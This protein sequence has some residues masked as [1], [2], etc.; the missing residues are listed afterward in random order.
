MN[1]HRRLLS[2]TLSVAAVLVLLAVSACGPASGTAT[3][4]PA[5]PNGTVHGYIPGVLLPKP[6]APVSVEILS[7]ANPSGAPIAALSTESD[8]F[9]FSVPPGAYFVRAS[10]YGDHADSLDF[11]VHPGATTNV[12]WGRQ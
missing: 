10:Y 2:P 8:S 1:G 5:L 7:V 12:Y 6:K 4:S 11:Q 3:K 9:T